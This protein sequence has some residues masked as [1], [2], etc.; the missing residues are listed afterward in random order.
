MN[1]VAAGLSPYEA[2]RAGS[3]DAA[4]FLH[5]EE[6]F[7]TVAVGGRADLLLLGGNP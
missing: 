5:R 7:G 1:F 3:S 2:L 4:R 6:E